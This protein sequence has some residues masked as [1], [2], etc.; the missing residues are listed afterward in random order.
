MFVASH[1][2]RAICRLAIA[3]IAWNS[4]HSESV[5]LTNKSYRTFVVCYSCNTQ[6]T[7]GFRSLHGTVA[8]LVARL[9]ALVANS[10]IRAITSKMARLVAVSA[11]GL[12]LA[13]AGNVARLAAVPANNLTRAIAGNV[14]LLVA[15]AANDRS[16]SSSSRTAGS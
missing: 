8:S 4:P 1:L 9:A 6:P 11:D 2:L 16:R 10:L 15:V 7:L 14:A 3:S 13:V 5:A 12:V